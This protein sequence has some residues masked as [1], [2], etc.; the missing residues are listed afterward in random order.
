[1]LKVRNPELESDQ[2][3]D[4]RTIMI[5][6]IFF[7]ASLCIQSTSLQI[8]AKQDGHLIDW[9]EPWLRELASHLTLIF[10]L[11]LFP[12]L[13]SAASFTRSSWPRSAF[14]Y[15]LAFILF[16]SLHILGMVG[17]RKIIYP[18]V[19]GET[20]FFGLSDPLSWIYESRKDAFTFA[21]IVVGFILS[22]AAEQNRLEQNVAEQE[23]RT[24]QR[25]ILKS[26][27]RSILLDANEILWAKSSANYVE[28]GIQARTYLARMTLS[29][30]DKLLAEAGSDHLR[31]HR[32]SLVKLSAI[33]EIV[34]K[35]QG[36]AEVHL[37]GGSILVCSRRYRE[38]LD[39][40][41]STNI[42][43]PLA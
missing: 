34:P 27:G 7:L 26:G 1:M 35:G 17:L 33:R 20:Y 39:N 2:R 24:D 36:D 8:E 9:R 22:R 37:D 10:L 5:F 23:A 38:V 19:L 13:I 6:L 28:V 11:P 4:R 16:S 40:K 30:L 12:K 3:A 29:A 31:I 21:M 41:V 42:A 43:E 15:L 25:I 32:S 14:I 18:A